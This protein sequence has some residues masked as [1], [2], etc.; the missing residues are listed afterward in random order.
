MFCYGRE[1]VLELE[2]DRPQ[3][4]ICG[5]GLTV[6]CGRGDVAHWITVAKDLEEPGHW[7][8]IGSSVARIRRLRLWL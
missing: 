8:R 3:P 4:P 5:V 7:N 2:Y 6:S 1:P